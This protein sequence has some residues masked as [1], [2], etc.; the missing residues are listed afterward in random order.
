MRLRGE[1]AASIR[2]IALLYQLVNNSTTAIP[3]SELTIRYWYTSD[4][5]SVAQSGFCDSPSGCQYV[6][7]VR[8]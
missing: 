2:A 4:G 8:S 1:A 6:T 7:P 3:M 5:Q